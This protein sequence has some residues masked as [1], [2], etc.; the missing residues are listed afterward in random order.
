[1]RFAV[2]LCMCAL[3]LAGCGAAAGD[4]SAPEVTK[5]ENSPVPASSREQAPDTARV[6]CERDKTRLPTPGVRARPDG[7]HFEIENRLG[8]DTGYSVEYSEGGV[9][10]NAPKGESS[11]TVDFPPGEVRI[12]CYPSR[13]A[14]P[15][16]A[17]LTVLAGGSGYKPVEL[18]CPGGRAVTGM[19]GVNGDVGGVG[20]DPVAFV[21][22]KLSGRLEEGDVVEAAGYPE[23]R[24]ER[25]VRVVRDGRGIFTVSYHR[26]GGGW[27]ENEFSSCEGF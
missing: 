17:K 10:D 21:R 6:V 1:M 9:G 11:H 8:K 19:D 2:I 16:Y 13:N 26:E 20:E 15:D 5:P 4:G 24:K 23:S 27:L 12:G 18:E 7:V 25:S 22:R 3:A 14:D